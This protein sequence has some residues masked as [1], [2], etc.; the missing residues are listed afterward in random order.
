MASLDKMPG[1]MEKFSVEAYTKNFPNSADYVLGPR[2]EA[3]ALQKTVRFLKRSVESVAQ[4]VDTE[5]S[6]QGVRLT[7]PVTHVRLQQ[8]KLVFEHHPWVDDYQQLLEQAQA[9]DDDNLTDAQVALRQLSSVH[10]KP[11]ALRQRL[12]YKLL[13]HFC[14]E[15]LTSQLRVEL[16]LYLMNVFDDL[17][18][19]RLGGTKGLWRS[20]LRFLDKNAV[21]PT[22]GQ[23]ISGIRSATA[24]LHDLASIVVAV[25]ERVKAFNEIAADGGIQDW[26]VAQLIRQHIGTRAQ[27]RLH[28]CI[29]DGRAVNPEELSTLKDW[30]TMWFR[31]DDRD[32]RGVNDA[33]QA[34]RPS[35]ASTAKRKGPAAS[36]KDPS[37]SLPKGPR[38]NQDGGAAKRTKGGGRGPAEGQTHQSRS[39]ESSSKR[40]GD[41]EQNGHRGATKE[42]ICFRCGASGHRVPE[43][44]GKATRPACSECGRFHHPEAKQCPKTKNR[45][46]RK[47]GH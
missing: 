28:S 37:R 21:K 44:Q 10:L 35:S 34:G 22:I 42:V 39:G 4:N 1:R 30:T 7:T 8:L 24:K 17:D 16:Q 12:L 41:G 2:C 36:R 25:H 46:T 18:Q 11:L 13:T 6:G 20:I 3:Q 19:F 15:C 9:E 38:Q 5:W 31:L 14:H 45:K 29:L 23:V 27:D 47:A 32:R 33:I 43:C 40:G 26:Q